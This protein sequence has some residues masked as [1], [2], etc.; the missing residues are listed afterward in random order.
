MEN[1]NLIDLTNLIE[2]VLGIL[3]LIAMKY[4]LPWL[5]AR[6]TAEQEASFALIV[7]IAVMAAEK[8]YGSQHGEDKLKY[9]EEYLEARGIY[10]DTTR[11]RAYVNSAIKKMEQSENG[12]ITIVENITGA[13]MPEEEDEEPQEG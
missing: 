6:M 9:V 12:G 4:L 13:V 2:A 3:F 11:I 5:K 8:I 1:L 10:I 7:E